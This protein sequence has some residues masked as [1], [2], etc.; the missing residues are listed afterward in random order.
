MGTPEPVS[1]KT[2][3]AAAADKLVQQF[4]NA[5]WAKPDHQWFNA[6][7]LEVMKS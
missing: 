1:K 5:E 3:I 2:S 4:S 6:F 7:L